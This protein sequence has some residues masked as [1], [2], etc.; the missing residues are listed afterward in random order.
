MKREELISRHPVLYHVTARGAWP[1]IKEHG[2]LTTND[3]LGMCDAVLS[4]PVEGRWGRH[5]DEEGWRLMDDQE[6]SEVGYV[7][8]HDCVH[9]KAPESSLTAIIR[10]QEPLSDDTLDRQLSRQ[11]KQRPAS[12]PS[13]EAWHKRQNDRAFFFPTRAGAEV[14]ATKY[15]N[16]DKKNPKDKRIPKN[17]RAPQD[18]LVVCTKSL[19]DEYG[20]RIELSARN[21]GDLRREGDLSKKPDWY[22]RHDEL[23]LTLHRFDYEAWLC[24]SPKQNPVKEVT[25][26]GG[27]PDISDHVIKVVQMNG[28]SEGKRLHAGH[29]QTCVCPLTDRQIGEGLGVSS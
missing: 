11:R 23:F 21:S 3:L 22:R 7:A 9:V 25:V 26:R 1:S 16:Q 27:V 10:D 5:D 19:V 12:T 20:K 6:R 14:M 29:C 17:K 8:R 13:F 18:M 15:R 4:L 2:L 24:R 28:P